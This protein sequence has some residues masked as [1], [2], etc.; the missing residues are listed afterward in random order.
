MIKS[1]NV[2][3]FIVTRYLQPLESKFA[4]A[5]CLSK[6]GVLAYWTSQQEYIDLLQLALKLAMHYGSVWHFYIGLV[7][8]PGSKEPRDGWV[9]VHSVTPVTTTLAIPWGKGE[10][11]QHNGDKMVHAEDCGVVAT[12]HRQKAT[13]LIDDFPC[14]YAKDGKWVFGG[15]NRKRSVACRL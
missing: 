12:Y 1:G 14:T 13:R 10:P 6:G 9:W 3:F 2:T 5:C 7:Q 15:Y 11:N 4:Q 8:L